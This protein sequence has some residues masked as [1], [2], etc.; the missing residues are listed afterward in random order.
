[1]NWSE[2]GAGI[3]NSFTTLI[4]NRMHDYSKRCMG[5]TN[6]HKQRRYID[7]RHGKAN[8]YFKRRVK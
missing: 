1:M 3:V 2:N 4:F 6:P 8:T 7:R 5:Q